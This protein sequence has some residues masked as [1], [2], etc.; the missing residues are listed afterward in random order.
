MPAAAQ[1]VRPGRCRKDTAGGPTT[2]APRARGGTRRLVSRRVADRPRGSGRGI[3]RARER[4]RPPGGDVGDIGCEPHSPQDERLEHRPHAVAG[5]TGRP[6]RVAVTAGPHHASA[7]I[8]ARRGPPA[9]RLPTA[10]TMRSA[11]AKPCGTWGCDAASQ[12]AGFV[13]G[14]SGTTGDAIASRS[15]PIAGRPAACRHRPRHSSR[16]ARPRQPSSTG[17]DHRWRRDA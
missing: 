11:I 17:A 4:C 13:T 2:R 8:A 12:A 14:A 5:R 3:R 6:V 9:G 1:P 16:P 7:C 10:A 15:C